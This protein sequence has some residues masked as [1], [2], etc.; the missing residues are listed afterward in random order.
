MVGHPKHTVLVKNN[1]IQYMY[2]YEWECT[3]V[4]DMH[5]LSYMYMHTK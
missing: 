2:I 1:S 3:V 5:H 4:I